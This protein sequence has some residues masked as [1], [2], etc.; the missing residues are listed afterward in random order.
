MK[1]IKTKVFCTPQALEIVGATLIKE[2]ITGF[3]INDPNNIDELN[4]AGGVSWDYIDE[5]LNVIDINDCN[6]EFY[7][8]DN[9]QGRNTL[10]NVQKQIKQLRYIIKDV[11][12][13]QLKLETTISD[14][15]DWANAWKKYFKSLKVGN[16]FYIKP[17]WEELLNSDNRFIVE[18]DPSN[19]FG[20]GTHA[21]TQLC[22][23]ALE[24]EKLKGAHVLDLGCGSGIL[25]IG[26]AL[27]G[28]KKITFVDIDEHCIQ[29][30]KLNAKQNNLD[31]TSL[32][33]HI[34][35]IIDNHKL[36]KDIGIRKFD[37][38]IANIMADVIILMS[39][40]FNRFLK[41]DGILIVSGIIVERETDVIK[42][43]RKNSCDII[44]ILY[45]DGWCAIKAKNKSLI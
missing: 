35:N 23:K 24:Q 8:S 2:G 12:L 19:S 1:W 40:T 20:T 10:L 18:L 38:L 21:T 9:E 22:L 41:K 39:E 14:D 6:I 15:K 17:T 3:I 27:S 29:T 45:Q 42:A 36:Q 32:N 37:I 44:D 7:V 26:A 34:G 25:G 16:T 30:S 33:F 28:A 31:I 4:N 11:E 13:G 5:K 43:L